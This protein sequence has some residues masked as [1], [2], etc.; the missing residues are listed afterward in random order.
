MASY[1]P[2]EHLNKPLPPPL[3]AS[4]API[5]A[6]QR[7]D[8]M[9]SRQDTLASSHYSQRGNT[10]PMSSQFPPARNDTYT[11]SVYTQP[12]AYY[13]DASAHPPLPQASI[14]SNPPD[15]VG[16]QHLGSSP[17]SQ[18]ISTSPYETDL[19][20]HYASKPLPSSRQYSN[21][22]HAPL[23]YPGSS[24]QHSPSED[25]LHENAIP[26]Q[27]RNA[28]DQGADVDHVYE[29]PRRKASKKQGVR[30][31]ELGMLGSYGNKI[32]WVV[33]IFTAAQIGVF[34]G[35]IIQNGIAPP[36]SPPPTNPQVLVVN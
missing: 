3:S 10:L 36:K 7:S 33:Y 23:G 1:Y 28:K 16:Q 4:P 6:S 35:E 2:N 18:N 25:A 11:S 13:G 9:P 21:D 31:G 22:A 12:T 27:D 15:Y 34:I 32:P 20:D 26:L 17:H 8:T 29:A 24:S 5:D 19:D 14:Y 30:F